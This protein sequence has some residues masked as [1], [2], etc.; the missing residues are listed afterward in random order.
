MAP[1]LFKQSEGER[2]RVESDVGRSHHLHTY[3][4]RCVQGC[5]MSC[6]KDAKVFLSLS[7]DLFL[8]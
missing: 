8:V 2:E 5:L 4:R 3:A 1:L 6:V 7:S